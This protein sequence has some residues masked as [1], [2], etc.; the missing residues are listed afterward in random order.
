MALLGKSIEYLHRVTEGHGKDLQF[1]GQFLQGIR[2]KYV[3][4]SLSPGP[5]LISASR[6]MASRVA[7]GNGDSQGRIRA[8]FHHVPLGHFIEYP[9]DIP[10]FLPG[11]RVAGKGEIV[12]NPLVTEALSLLVDP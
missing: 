4:V 9:E 3:R 1:P 6:V 12:D 5:P 10:P 7:A 2:H 11:H 8:L